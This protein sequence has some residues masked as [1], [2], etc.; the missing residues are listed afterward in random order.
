MIE[1]KNLQKLVGQ[2]LAIDLEAL[3]VEAGEIAAL[4]GPEGSGKDVL[5]ELLIGRARPS[6]GSV[7]VAGIDPAAER[8]RFSRRAGVLFREDG[9]YE[10]QSPLANLAFHCR[11]HGLPKSRAVEVLA[12]VGLA[13]QA[14][15]KLNKLSPGLLR[16][17]AFGRAVLHRP[18]AL[19][20]VEPFARCDEA[21]I[22]LLRNLIRELAEDG[23]AVLILADDEANLT[24]LCDTIYVLSQGQIAESYRPLEERRAE[25]P[26]KVPAK[27]EDKVIL[28]NPG[29]ILCVAA[30]E[31]R[32]VLQTVDGRLPTQF[33]LAELEQ[34]LARSGFFR[35]HRGYLVN[36][37]HVREVIPYTRNS[38]SLRLD[39]ADRT[40]IP[41][42][43]SAARELRELLG[44]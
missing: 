39:D 15:A 44:Y 31:G 8:E 17:L 42:S 38:Y 12:Q 23:A 43:K 6:A 3:S 14:D 24:D 30:E 22:A 35:A 1:L 32:A 19:L 4:V 7:R 16:R 36:L 41:L 25:Q 2:S 9:L 34:R 27:A 10:Q 37:Q 13:D 40:E 26:F 29:D 18:E 5:L 11:L 28:V 33:T 21:S 20:L